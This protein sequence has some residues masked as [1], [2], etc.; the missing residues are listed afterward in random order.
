TGAQ[1][2]TETFNR[3]FD[4]EQVF[5]LQDELA[6]RIVCTVSD[7]FGVL[8][9]AMNEDL[10][11][12]PDEELTP[13]DAVLLAFG[14]I[15]R[16]TA[17]DHLRART[18]L[19]RAVRAAP[20]DASCWAMLSTIYLNEHMHGLNPLPDP[21]SRSLAAAR[22]AVDLGPT[23][24]MAH[25]ARASA[26]FFVKRFAAFRADAERALQLNPWDG[27]TLA[28][29]GALWACC[30]DW[31]EGEALL[32]RAQSYNP[33]HP[34]WYHS[35]SVWNRYRRGQYEEAL[36][37]L[38]SIRISVPDPLWATIRAAT[39]GQLG[40]TGPAREALEELFR[41]RPDF[42]EQLR[43]WLETFFQ[44][45]TILMVLDGL[46]KAGLED[47]AK[48]VE[49]DAAPHRIADGFWVAVLPFEATGPEAAT[50]FANGLFEETIT[51]MS[52]FSYLRLIARSS[53]R[54]YAGGRSDVRT[55]GREL[56]ARY[57]MEGSVRQA[58]AQIRLTVQISDVNTGAQ[59]WTETFA[60]PFDREQIFALQDELA[61][62]IVSTVSDSFGVLVR[63]MS[64]ELRRKP[65]EELTPH[66]AVLLA[67]GFQFNVT[68]ES[69]LR[70][71]TALERAVVA[72]PNDGTCW[73]WLAM[74][75]F[76]EM[77]HGFNRQP[78]PIGRCLA[79]AQKGVDVAPTSSLAHGAVA[80]AYFF[81]R[82]YR[83]FRVEAER[84]MELNPWDGAALVAIGTCWA[85]CVDQGEGEALIA[86]GLS[87][88]PAH[89]P[90]GNRA[91][92][93]RQYRQG[94]YAAALEVLDRAGLR[95]NPEAALMRAAVLGQLGESGPAREALEELFRLRPDSPEQLSNYLD[96]LFQPEVREHILDGLRKAG[97]ETPAASVKADSAEQRVADGFWVAVLPF[98]AQ[99]SDAAAE[100]AS[101]LFEETLTGMSR[102]SYLRLIARSSV[103][104]YAGSRSDVRTIGQELGARYVMEGSVRQAG[105]QIRLTVQISD[106]SSGVQLWTET[107]HRGFDPAQMF[108]LQDE[109]APRIVSTVSDSCGVLVRAMS[110]VLRR[111]PDDDLTVHEAILLASCYMFS[112]E[113]ESHLRA[114]SALER[115]VA[116]DPGHA[117]CWVWLAI[118]YA[119]EQLL[120]FNT[121]PDVAA[122]TLSA[123]RKAVELDPA[124]ALAH[125]ALAYCCFLSKQVPE[126]RL[127][128]QRAMELNPWDGACMCMLGYLW[129]HCIDWDEGEAMAARGL[130][131]S[132]TLPGW[133]LHAAFWNQF[134]KRNFPA[135]LELLQKAG[136]VGRHWWPLM[137]ATTYG[138]MGETGR[139]QEAVRELLQMRPD[140]PQQAR[141]IVERFHRPE[142]VEHI[143]EGLRKAGLR[144]VPN[145]SGSSGTNEGFWVSVA[146]FKTS[147]SASE[148]VALAEALTEEVITGLSRFSYLRILARN[149]NAA[150]AR[151]VL[152]GS[153]RQAGS[154][155]RVAVRLTDSESGAHLWAETYD[156]PFHADQIFA[157]QDDLIPRIV[158]TAGDRFGVL[159]RSI[160]E[161]VRGK[162]AP[163]FT[164]YEALMRAF[165]YH[166][167]LTAQ[168]HAE[169][170]EALELAVERAPGNADCWAMLAWVYSHEYGHGFNPR[171]DPLE[172]AHTAA[173]RAVDL[174]PSNQLAQQAL[175]VVLLFRR[176]IAASLAACERALELNPNDGSNE[177]C[178]IIA[179]TGDWDRGGRLIRHAME[180]NPHHPR[181]YR[182]ML[183]LGEY[184]RG[185]YR[186]A[187]AEVTAANISAI[188]WSPVLLAA[189]YAQLGQTAEARVALKEAI[190]L[191]PDLPATAR[192]M[193]LRWYLEGTGTHL[194]EGLRKA[195]LGAETLPAPP[196]DSGI[197]RLQEGFWVAVLPFKSGSTDTEV[198]S[199]ADGLA[200]EIVTGLSRFSYLR[201]IGRGS[202][203]R[204]AGQP[205]DL[206]TVGGEL[207]ARYVM[208]GSLRHAGNRLRLTVQLVDTSSGVQIWAETYDRAFDSRTLFEV[209]D[210][211]APRIVSTVADLDGVLP[212][213]MA[214]SLRAK[215]EDQLSPHEALLR[216]LRFFKTFAPE[217]HALGI[218]ILERAVQQAPGRGDC[219]AMLSHLYSAEYWTV[220]EARANALDLALA[221]A[222]R[223]VD[224]APANSL[225][226]WALALAL[227]F[228]R[229]WTPFRAAAQRAI[230]LNPMDGSV[231]T[232]MGHLIAYAGEWDRGAAI[233]QKGSELNPLHAGWHG[234]LPVLAAYQRRDYPAALEAALRLD[235]GGLVHEFA[236]RAACYAQ[237]GRSAEAGAALK[238]LLAI[239]PDPAYCPGF[240]GR[241]LLP[242]L[243]AHVVEGLRKAGLDLRPP[244]ASARA[245]ASQ[246]AATRTLPIENAAPFIAVLPFANLS[247]DK[248]QEYF[249]DGLAEEILNLLAQLPGLKTIARTS[250]FAFRGKEDDVRSIAGALN[251]T[252]VLQGSVRRSGDRIRVTAQLIAASDGAT[253]W[254]ERYD[255]RMEDLFALQDEIAAAITSQLKVRVAPGLTKPR[256]QPNL[257]AYEAYLR[258]RQH[259]WEFTPEAL[260][261]SR[262]CLERAISLDPE[263]ALP[264]VGLA[265]HFFVQTQFAPA[266]EWVPKIRKMAARA[267]ALDPELSE[268]QAMH[269]I[270]AGM[271]DRNW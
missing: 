7:S 109:L 176:E 142:M 184:T 35:T 225:S 99:G 112:P 238:Q 268:A 158:S 39:L 253:L 104:K 235:M 36:A 98:E 85:S 28:W 10:R 29:V 217:E 185:N 20:D 239:M 63:A 23:N 54:K 111:K 128:A 50:S 178:F 116:A 32:L 232:F 234:L 161:A 52:R 189:A 75:F 46:R 230:D 201:V 271:F 71:R 144:T 44:Q 208:E 265:D 241:F 38:Q 105:A 250:S 74:M 242:D 117:N 134:W 121:R 174:A 202:T 119:A 249:S 69:H 26:H 223:A 215:P 166:Q 34:Y 150:N 182:W 127:A 83:E 123:A 8:V 96:A 160:S 197:S 244:S 151:Y 94:N 162:P 25:Y 21:V 154:A 165:G 173:L 190:A 130:A 211:L 259:Q 3:A 80:L 139:A 47:L 140:A 247:G 206:R 86:R 79:A 138:H 257:E 192:G 172:R 78:D 147:A 246:A 263:F 153:L 231:T 90:M 31:D 219:H 95:G 42:P 256:R 101:G 152:E 102:F 106:V 76:H 93:W 243:A 168:D 24:S 72:E 57:V 62:R 248:D 213:S 115:A 233:A 198:T 251:V 212:Q 191:K 214:E 49:A 179:M 100:F 41:L 205:T 89:P 163:Q 65:D 55:I 187:I 103:R 267:I 164:P 169:A 228:R 40:Q 118:L 196:P 5:A 170:R 67:C 43:A 236:L 37:I 148:I 45:D 60:R 1:L 216:S 82:R 222:K 260:E 124:N 262:E 156:R 155:V 92:F 210:D 81:V 255:R 64:E 159:A 203:L 145:D 19:E 53:V 195:G 107:F 97:L 240:Y 149:A 122:R 221:A 183:G 207:G 22:R 261:R 220:T 77:N 200:E 171:P 181:W 13:H 58:G 15:F 108:A 68:A 30:L 237:L 258:Y 252:H 51:G 194:L 137:R 141:S 229:D 157:L 226:H 84:S 61:P 70:A 113:P 266:G 73:S 110:E 17:E 199:L 88:N 16:H 146:P 2:W 132:P 270:L 209:Q 177:A 204:Y 66:D 27:I 129:G 188:W 227:F 91:I 269:G 193:I 224:V 56:G 12:K 133:R 18:A 186:G 120:E 131:Y 125:M 114:R 87:Y 218:R 136:P 254:S 264:Y 126:F 143:L 14:Y 59:L 175:A 11:R 4:P 135:A 180:L 6:P 33:T 9:R 167:R 48:P 245:A